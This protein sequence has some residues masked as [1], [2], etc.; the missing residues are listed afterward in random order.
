MEEIYALQHYSF[1]FIEVELR[2]YHSCGCS[3]AYCPVFPDQSMLLGPLTK[4]NLSLIFIFFF[5]ESSMF[6]LKKEK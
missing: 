4:V 5:P 3:K 1:M 2:E 6:S